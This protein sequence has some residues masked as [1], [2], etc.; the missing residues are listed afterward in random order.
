MQIELKGINFHESALFNDFAGVNLTIAL[1][2][3]FSATLVYGFA[4]NLS[5]HQYFFTY[6]NDK[7]ADGL[8][9]T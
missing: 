2:N 3:I 1:R 7:I 6:T 4:N 5:K 8:E 9:K